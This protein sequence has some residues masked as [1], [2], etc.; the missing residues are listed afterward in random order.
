MEL[1]Q[2]AAR[3]CKGGSG[4]QLQKYLSTETC[5]LQVIFRWSTGLPCNCQFLHQDQT[6]QSIA[7][8]KDLLNSIDSHSPVGPNQS[9]RAA[10]CLMLVSPVSPKTCRGESEGPWPAM[11]PCKN[12]SC[13]SCRSSTLPTLGAQAV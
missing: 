2:S 6:D 3:E 7:A 9:G 12:E 5:G 8:I 4:K 10:I 1:E 13:R 11:L